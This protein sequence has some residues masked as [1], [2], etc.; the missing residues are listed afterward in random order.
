MP[1]L[2]PNTADIVDPESGLPNEEAVLTAEQAHSTYKEL[3]KD[4]R[5]RNAK[6]SA[7][8]RKRDG[9][10][11]WSSRKL[12]AAG[13]SWRS[14]RPTGFMQSMLKRLSPPYKQMLD[15][16]PLLTY[17]KF[18]SKT[19]GTEAQQDLFQRKITNTMRQHESWADYLSRL[20]DEDIVFGYTAAVCLDEYAW[21]PEIY[22]GDEI[23]FPVGALQDVDKLELFG[24]RQ[25]KRVHEVMELLKDPV[26]SATA[27]WKI[28]NLVQKLNGSRPEHQD[29]T[30]ED[31]TR[32]YQ[33]LIRE[34]NMG[35]SFSSSVRVVKMGHLLALDPS[36]GVNHYIFDRDDG[37]PFFFRRKR[38][39]SMRH[40]ISLFSAEIGDR[41]LHGSR[42]A[43]RTLYNTHISVEQARNLVQ[44]A[45]HL[46]GLIVLKRTKREAGAGST[47]GPALS[48]NHPFAIV[49]DGYE[50]VDKVKFEVNSEA[51][52]ALDNQATTQA[53]V[54]VGAFMPGQIKD[55]TGEKATAS[56]INYGASI[57][58]QIRAGILSRFA[59]QSFNMTG[60]IQRR[61]CHPEVLQLAKA[62]A[63]TILAKSA[64]PIYDKEFWKDLE[65]VNSTEG[66]ALVVL[67]DYIDP[68]AVQCCAE[69]ISEGLTPQQILI[70]ANASPRANVDDAIASQSGVLDMVVSSYVADPMID[71]VEL[72]RRHLSSKLG[73]EA[74]ERLLKA[75]L[76]PASDAREAF[77][78]LTELSIM[79]DGNDATIETQDND[80]IHLSTLQGRVAPMLQDAA[81]APMASSLTFLQRVLAHATGHIQ[82]ATQKGTPP[83]VL[84]PFQQLVDQMGQFVQ[85]KS[86]ESQAQATIDQAT[87]AGN[88]P[89][90][91]VNIQG[92]GFDPSEGQTQQKP[93]GE[94]LVP[95]APPIGATPQDI[96][97]S[98]A[99][100]TRPRPP[101]GAET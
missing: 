85:Q 36:G 30:G 78:Q 48:V 92:G 17:S 27:G 49:G 22:R 2:A 70:L 16:L 42:G 55:S 21:M 19:M 83:K 89:G 67:P 71:T 84:A 58:A 72:K 93:A 66:F 14:N 4:N 40:I 60:M 77:R 75:D 68:E 11:P 76:S 33:D 69:L 88:V 96:A 26:A 52:I 15:Q 24:V 80:I 8:Q 18:P 95:D 23:L 63:E 1:A 44:D 47:E 29:Y 91:P 64:M 3:V 82:S 56:E 87:A 100:P 97:L 45:L 41:T 28:D 25:N 13:Q 31:N 38:F 5:E 65:T 99:A 79:L 98:A 32:L 74:A 86:I 9:E 35:S 20:I 59:D 37:T 73:A 39:R 54:A 61:I 12:K 94:S 53:E 90:L 81:V 46:S 101:T 43:G 57:D 50:A 62:V 10:Q 6:N 7:V 51:F 34:N